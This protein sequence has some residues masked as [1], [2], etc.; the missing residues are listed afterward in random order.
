MIIFG[1]DRPPTVPAHRA[2]LTLDKEVST[3]GKRVNL[4]TLQLEDDPVEG[5]TQPSVVEQSNPADE[6]AARAWTPVYEAVSQAV[7]YLPPKSIN[8]K[9]DKLF[10]KL[11]Q[12]PDDKFTHSIRAVH[13]GV[14]ACFYHLA[15]IETLEN[16]MLRVAEANLPKGYAAFNGAFGGGNTGKVTLEFQSFIL[17][18]KH[19]LEYFA[20]SAAL[21]LGLDSVRDF[22]K[23]ERALMEDDKYTALQSVLNKYLPILK[24]IYYCEDGQALRNQISHHSPLTYD[25]IAVTVG[26]KG[27]VAVYYVEGQ[28]FETIGAQD[29]LKLHPLVTQEKGHVFAASKLLTT[30]S[31]RFDAALNFIFE[32]YDILL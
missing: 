25:Q 23:L 28:I 6:A 16:A 12:K 29:L 8:D 27:A 21:L 10:K 14:T 11:G 24:P 17:A 7:G 9:F 2:V 22:S 30:I 5:G 31:A 19:L 1:E 4:E 15:N 32:A 3:I 26:P 20:K 18:E 13:R